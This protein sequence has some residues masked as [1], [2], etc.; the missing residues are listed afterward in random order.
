ML[1]AIG[2]VLA[3]LKVLLVVLFALFTLLAI[4]GPI[5]TKWFSLDLNTKQRR[6]LFA[7]AA[8]FALLLIVVVAR[9]DPS[10]GASAPVE[11]QATT[12]ALD[13]PNF[14]YHLAVTGLSRDECVAK[15][16]QVLAGAGLTGITTNPPVVYGYKQAYLVA[17]ACPPGQQLF[18]AAGKD[19]SRVRE[20]RELLRRSY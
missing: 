11:G 3:D 9:A 17:V 1:D 8:L 15:A 14:A 6:A 5:Q 7:C 2:K 19:I 4:L 13:A 16:R 10:S 18:V 12:T 20:L